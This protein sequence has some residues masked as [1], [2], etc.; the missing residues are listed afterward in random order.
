MTVCVAA[1]SIAEQKTVQ[2]TI[3]IKTV[4]F[5]SDIEYNRSN[6]NASIMIFF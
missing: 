4:D 6:V 3:F 2:T 1:W 5:F